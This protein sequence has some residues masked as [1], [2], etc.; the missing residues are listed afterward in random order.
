MN[1]NNSKKIAV[2]G[3]TG[4][5][6][7]NVLNVADAYPEHFSVVGLAAGKNIELLSS[8]ILKFKPLL[9]SV[10]N[11][12]LA[13]ELRKI[14]KDKKADS[15]LEI[16]FGDEG[17]QSVATMPD[18][19]MVVSSVV[20]SIGI[21]PVI[22][23]INA[24]K[25]IAIANKE[26][27]VMAGEL[28]M[29]LAS[30]KGVSI[31]PIDSEHSAIFQCLQGHRKNEIKRLILTASGGPFFNHNMC[32]LTNITPEMAIKHPVWSMGKKI[33]VD[34]ATMMNKGLEV[35]EARWLFDIPP[36]KIDIIVHPQSIIH[37]MV[38]YIDGSI[39]AQ[40]GV[41]DMKTPIQYALSYPKRLPSLSAPLSLEEIG[42]LSFKKPDTTKFPCIK[43]CYEALNTGGTAPAVL[44]AADEI[45]VELFVS[46]RIGFLDIP[47]IVEKTLLA[48]S[49][50]LHPSLEN[51]IT[52]EKWAR[53]Y[54]LSNIR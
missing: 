30:N 19:D 5:I 34:S 53:N 13:N 17:L 43:M 41:P 54:I 4:S 8:Q 28:I 45:A 20:G 47:N 35:I 32:Q 29:E 3:S 52:A 33:S 6:G 50:I 10:K 46:G 27:L 21:K 48:H 44:A 11:E 51:I 22:E 31:V 14:L 7:I 12:S 1:R 25:N 16:L 15:N 23:A 24:R 26:A 39:I 42:T 36:D 37:S 40:L 38:E 9:V 49:P 2:L 18:I